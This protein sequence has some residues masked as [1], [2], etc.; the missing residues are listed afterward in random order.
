[1]DEEHVYREVHTGTELWERPPLTRM[2]EAIRR[3]EVDVVVAFAIDRLSRKPVH[4][5]VI[6]TEADHA[7]V[8]VEFV[9]EQID[10]S[11]EG[12]LIRFVRGYAAQVEHEKIKERTMRGRMARAKAGKPLPGPRPRYGYQWNEDR[13][14]LL[15]DP[16]TAPVVQRIFREASRGRSVFAIASGLSEDGITRPSGHDRDGMNGTRWN[17]RTVWLILRDVLYIGESAACRHSQTSAAVPLPE[18]TVPALVTRAEFDTVQGRMES[19][20]TAATRNNRAPE[21]TLVRGGYA[22][23]GYCGWVMHVV[24]NGASVSYR[25]RRGQKP[26]HNGDCQHQIAAATLDGAVW[27]RVA[28]VLLHPELIAAELE[29][30]RGSDPS[31]DD[32]AAVE[33]SLTQVVRQQR[34]LI[35]QLANVSG[36][37]AT[38]ITDKINALETQR[39]QLSGEQEAILARGQSWRAAQERIGDIQAWCRTV[40]TNLTTL[41]YGEKRLALDALGVEVK[42]WRA[43][44]SPRYEIRASMPLDTPSGDIACTT[45]STL[46]RAG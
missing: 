6:F 27:D 12:E 9:T 35:E 28:G 29:R 43:D 42:V 19:N 38:F 5:G 1:M 16:L 39:A 45:C 23:C 44:H 22:R 3:R 34:N 14:R 25:C 21:A 30:M 26:G 41:T 18:G 46:K 40:A 8:A 24:R 32:L 10:D 36:V 4:L 20:R 33:R 15:P 31:A 17:F 37:A 2:R 7:G 13:T 11:P